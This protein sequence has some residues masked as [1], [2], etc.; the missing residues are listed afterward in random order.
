V[1]LHPEG[2]WALRSAKTTQLLYAVLAK[3]A[4]REAGV[5]D[6]WLV[7]NGMVTEGT[8]ANAHIIDS[9][10][11]LVS[12]PVDHGVLPGISRFSVLPLAQDMGL[13]VEERAF[14]VDELFAAREAFITSATT[15]VMPVVE[16]DGRKIGDGRPGALTSELRRRYIERLRVA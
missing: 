2:R 11:V 5:D 14:S 1:I 10:G 15:V 8:S 13:A 6:A 7:D 12:H 9:R 3:E 4:A 16:V